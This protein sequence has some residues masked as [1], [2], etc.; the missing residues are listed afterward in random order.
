MIELESLAR[1]APL[2]TK[3]SELFAFGLGTPLPIAVVSKP[4]TRPREM[5]NEAV[6]CETNNDSTL[7]FELVSFR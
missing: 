7:K 1:T 3:S 2:Y 4:P 6:I 5:I